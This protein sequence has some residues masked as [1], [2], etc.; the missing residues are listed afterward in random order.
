MANITQYVLVGTQL[1]GW[2]DA[3]PNDAGGT[4][5]VRGAKLIHN[6]ATP[7]TEWINADGTLTGWVQVGSA[8]STTH[9]Y[10]TWALAF[11]DSA[12]WAPGDYLDIATFPELFKVWAEVTENGGAFPARLDGRP[13]ASVTRVTGWDGGN[14]P[15]VTADPTPWSNASGVAVNAITPDSPV[16]GATK[17]EGVDAAGFAFV[18]SP[19]LTTS[20]DTRLV[21]VVQSVTAFVSSGTGKQIFFYGIGYIGANNTLN[22]RFG[23]RS[24]VSATNWTVLNSGGT[25]VDSGLTFTDGEGAWGFMDAVN[26]EFTLWTTLGGKLSQAAQNL[27]ATPPTTFPVARVQG[28]DAATISGGSAEGHGQYRVTLV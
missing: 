18:Q 28:G 17:F 4:A 9:E 6:T 23:K 21:T 24:S 3:P 15:T 22:C 7:A 5:G 14:D 10:A 19:V 27:A 11:A 8:G 16:V 12:A 20:A 13:V 1:I 26:A 2:C 25:E